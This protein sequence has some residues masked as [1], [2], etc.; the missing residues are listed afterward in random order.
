MAQS[1]EHPTSAWVMISWLKPHIGLSAVSMEPTLGPLS[2]SLSAPRLLML[3][4]SKINIKK[5][6]QNLLYECHLEIIAIG[7]NAWLSFNVLFNVYLFL[8]ESACVQVGEGQREGERETHTHTQSEAGSR[9]RAV[10]TEPNMGLEP[11]NH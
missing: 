9:L 5:T 6:P 11:T 10:S 1:V 7:V 3:S 2:P 8:R 4:V